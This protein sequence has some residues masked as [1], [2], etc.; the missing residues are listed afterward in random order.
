MRKLVRFGIGILSLAIVVSVLQIA[1][2]AHAQGKKGIVAPKNPNTEV[3]LGAAE[4]KM[5]AEAWYAEFKMDFTGSRTKYA[6]K[7]IELTGKVAGF[8]EEYGNTRVK[9][10][11]DK[12][13]ATFPC[14]SVDRRPWLKAAPGAVIKVKGIVPLSGSVGDLGSAQI[15]DA[16]KYDAITLT[17]VQLAAE[18]KKSRKDAS[19]KYDRKWCNLSGDI[20]E[21]K[22]APN[23]RQAF[24]KSSNDVEV[25]C[26]SGNI[27]KDDPIAGLKK[28][29]KVKL[30]GQLIVNEREEKK[31][32]L[33]DAM[34]SEPR[35]K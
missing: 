13:G 20:L 34:L 18:Y 28:G 7:V 5:T 11:G 29:A 12:S 8:S 4:V 21:V 23:G 10:E 14:Y 25:I 16:G 17:A 2:D 35:A 31:V 1:G 26:F 30:F 15:I 3:K 24:L 6:G 27:G 22:D 9:L 19:S 33:I 32:F